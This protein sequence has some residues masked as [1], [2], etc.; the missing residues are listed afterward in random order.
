MLCLVIQQHWPWCS[1]P[2]KPCFFKSTA[3]VFLWVTEVCHVYFCWE[4]S[5]TRGFYR[6]VKGNRAQAPLSQCEVLPYREILIIYYAHEYNTH[7][8]ATLRYPMSWGLCSFTDI[9]LALNLMSMAWSKQ[10]SSK[11]GSSPVFLLEDS[12][13]IFCVYRH[14]L[15]SSFIANICNWITLVDF[16]WVA[17]IKFTVIILKIGEGW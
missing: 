7:E 3:F 16:L 13:N 8:S 4:L 15:T 6:S 14:V 9:H 12:S 5:G 1:Q 10:K 17:F 2:C 11:T